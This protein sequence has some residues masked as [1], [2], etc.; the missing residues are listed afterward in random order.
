MSKSLSGPRSTA[1]PEDAILSRLK[2]LHAEGRLVP[3]VGAGISQG[4]GLPDWSQLLERIGR[5]L[6]FDARDFLDNGTLP[7][8]AEYCLLTTGSVDPLCE[9]MGR[10]FHSEE[11]DGRRKQS[12]VH[13]LLAEADFSRIYTTNLDEH[14]EMAFEDWRRP[15]SVIRDIGDLQAPSKRGTEVVKFHGTL[16]LA[17][18]V[19]LTETSYLRRMHFEHPLDLL[20][21]ADSLRAAF[22]FMGYS[23]S[24][25]NIRF[26]WNALSE[27]RRAAPDGRRGPDS[28]LRSALLGL[29][30]SEVQR[31]LLDNWD[32]DVIWIDAEDPQGSMARALHRVT[33]GVAGGKDMPR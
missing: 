4:L 19:V 16:S 15:V 21:R 10:L 13:R 20:L 17:N 6:G 24:D 9:L 23:F 7:Q 27:M 22:L 28:R 11:A 14:M 33:G 30:V 12:T 5:T 32:I 29:E 3:F 2:D 31:R 25:T 8:L 26:I 18:T 1:T